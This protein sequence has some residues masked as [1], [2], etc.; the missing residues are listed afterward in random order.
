MRVQDAADN[1]AQVH[2]FAVITSLIRLG[3]SD[4][5]VGEMAKRGVL[6]FS[7]STGSRPASFYQR[8][9]GL[10]WSYLPANEIIGSLYSSYICQEVAGRQVLDSGSYNG[11]TRRLGLLYTT[12][13]AYP[14][15][16]ELAMQVKR[17]VE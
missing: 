13:P 4:V 8:F 6:D 2:P 1:Y 14:D 9:P 5:Y 16:T 7:S 15:L 10:V 11:Q 12:D 17:E 3:Y